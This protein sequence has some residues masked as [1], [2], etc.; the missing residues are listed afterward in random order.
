MDNK[1]RPST[2]DWLAIA[3]AAFLTANLLHVADHYRQELAGLNI[4]V[5]LLGGL[6]TAS[7][8][9][10][11]VAVRRWWPSAPL[12]ATLVGF[13]AFVGVSAVHI[14]PDWGVISAS[15]SEDIRPDTLAWAVMGAE[16][17]AG[18]FLGVVGLRALR[19]RRREGVGAVLGDRSD[20]AAPNTLKA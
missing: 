12:L 18:F 3:A 6:V 1:Q 17:V 13:Y 5:M 19:A 10:T 8:V 11:L 16:V 4:L 15:Y 7:A 9:G 20:R 14:A 2:R